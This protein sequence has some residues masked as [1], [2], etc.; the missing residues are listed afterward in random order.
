MNASHETKISNSN[1][2]IYLK[3]LDKEEQMKPK[4]SRGKEITKSKA[5]INDVETKKDN[6]KDQ[7]LVL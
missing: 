3:E 1:L 5:Q 6:R 7:S 2:N 4:V